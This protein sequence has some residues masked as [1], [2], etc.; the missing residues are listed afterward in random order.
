MAKPTQMQEKK[1]ALA[2]NQV[3]SAKRSAAAKAAGK[4]IPPGSS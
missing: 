3:E 1:L 2:M 4:E